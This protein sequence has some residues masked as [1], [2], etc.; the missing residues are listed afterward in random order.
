[1]AH[2]QQRRTTVRRLHPDNPDFLAA[3]RKAL[4][5]RNPSDKGPSAMAG[6]TEFLENAARRGLTTDVLAA[7]GGETGL[8]FACLLVESP[9]AA[10]ML[11]APWSGIDTGDV[12]EVRSAI[13]VAVSEAA[14]RGTAVVE[15]LVSGPNETAA[16]CL[17]PSGFRRLTQLVYLQRRAS[18]G[19]PSTSRTVHLEWVTYS[20]DRVALFVDALERSYHG[21]LDCPELTGLRRTQDVLL[22]HRASGEF[23]PA[24]WFVACRDDA[25]VGVLLLSAVTGGTT[26]EV[27]YMGVAQVARGTG[28]S[29][30]LLG[31]AVDAVA[32]S[33]A[34]FMALAVDSRNAPARRLYGRWGFQEIARRDAWIATPAIA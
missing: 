17:A 30:A 22:A 11:V 9:G 13:A 27:V 32:R 28:V 21:S 19:K 5:L 18:L 29:D 3:V 4:D 15:A 20:E 7:V 33:R 24:L 23:D 26:L 16:A 14:A 31:R 12:D 2:V 34:T 10:A 1:M 6:A 8:R 25:P